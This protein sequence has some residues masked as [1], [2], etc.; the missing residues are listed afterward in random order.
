MSS[1]HNDPASTS[2]SSAAASS[3][4]SDIRVEPFASRVKMGAGISVSQTHPAERRTVQATVDGGHD[5][6]FEALGDCAT[7]LRAPETGIASENPW[8]SWTREARLYRF[9][10]AG[11]YPF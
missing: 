3:A 11:H 8:S 6:A 5:R 2:S 9:R 7:T 10:K 4:P 1:P